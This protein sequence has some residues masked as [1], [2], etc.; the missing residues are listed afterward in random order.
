M[1]G[2]VLGYYFIVPVYDEVVCFLLVFRYPEF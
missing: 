1:G 2:Q